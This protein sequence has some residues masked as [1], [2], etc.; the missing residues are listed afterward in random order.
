MNEENQ[1]FGPLQRILRYYIEVLKLQLVERLTDGPIE[2]LSSG[3]AS[4][5]WAH[6]K[7][8]VPID[9]PPHRFRFWSREDDVLVGWPLVTLKKNKYTPLFLSPST[10]LLAEDVPKFGPRGGDISLN[11][12]ALTVLG[13]SRAQK[14]ELT[15]LYQ[16][17]FGWNVVDR[18]N[19]AIEWLRV[20]KYIKTDLDPRQ[21]SLENRGKI[22][23]A[24]MLIAGGEA[25]GMQSLLTELLLLSEMDERDLQDG[26]LAQVFGLKRPQK[27]NATSCFASFSKLNLHQQ[28]AVDMSRQRSLSVVTGPPGT[29][30]SQVVVNAALAAILAGERVLVAAKNN[31]AIDVVFERVQRADKLFFP[32][33][34]GKKSLRIDLA[35]NLS[36][37]LKV[38]RKKVTIH[39]NQVDEAEFNRIMKTYHK[40]TELHQAIERLGAEKEK[41]L[42]SIPSFLVAFEHHKKMRRLLAECIA[43]LDTHHVNAHRSVINSYWRKAFAL[44]PKESPQKI[45]RKLLHQIYNTLVLVG[46]LNQRI[47][48]INQTKE[49]YAS[50]PS[51]EQMNEKLQRLDD[52][53]IQLGHKSFYKLY[54]KIP[55]TESNRLLEGAQKVGFVSCL[56]EA[57]AHF[58]LVGVTMLSAK[59]NLPLRAQEFDLLIIDEASQCDIPS[60]IPLLFRA[61]RVMCIGDPM[62]LPHIG[63]LHIE[64]KMAKDFQVPQSIL[65]SVNYSN[66]SLFDLIHRS[67]RQQSILLTHHYRSLP[68]II[69]FSNRTFYNS[70]LRPQ[71]EGDLGRSIVR[72]IDVEGDFSKVDGKSA[73]N[74]PEAALVVKIIVHNWQRWK[75]QN[76]KIGVVCP[77]RAH[78]DK[79]RGLLQ[80]Q[81]SNA[82]EEVTVDT[83]HRFQGDECDLILFSPV[84]CMGMPET[85]IE[86]AQTP[87]L[88]NVSLTRAKNR[89]IIVGD[90]EAC[91][92]VGGLLAKLARYTDDIQ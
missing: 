48:D 71:R 37:W 62:Q 44:W 83:V 30:K 51:F 86:F 22:K 39:K 90:K 21:L 6:P 82:F 61:K 24:A 74:V 13:L 52:A 70:K 58:P 49:V 72:W 88:L 28:L 78:V 31:Q 27:F 91:L 23:N 56:Q 1:Q 43:A 50:F 42:Q 32:I 38:K 3:Q 18:V 25:F 36:K 10:V 69:E 60:A 75:K 65:D 45:N 17:E 81:L 92:S 87:N 46:Q 54:S 34:V 41:I 59:S 77:F 20:K 80:Q 64:A 47:E 4:G 35:D 5:Y 53:R 73:I 33:R 85:L 11:S 15:S 66:N 29:G 19:G 89:L 8:W 79:I 26:V 16:T 63:S 57:L 12:Y 68:P 84:V 14:S 40:K 76:W 9:L 2:V 67:C 7:P 55:K